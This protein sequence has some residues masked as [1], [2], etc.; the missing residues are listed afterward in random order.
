MRVLV[1]GA[2]G[3]IGGHVARHL[4]SIGHDVVGATRRPDTLS[5]FKVWHVDLADHH[6]VWPDEY[7]AV[8]HCAGTHPVSGASLA[9]TTHDNIVP[10]LRLVEMA[11]TWNVRL[12]VFMSTTSVY[13]SIVNGGVLDERSDRLNPSV[14]GETKHVCEQIL[15]EQPFPTISLRMPQ[16]VGLGAHERNWMPKV[17][18]DIVENRTVSAFN[19]DRD[20]NAA[21]HVGDVCDLVSK[22]LDKPP[23]GHDELVLGAGGATTVRDVITILGRRLGRSPQIFQVSDR[24]PSFVIRSDRAIEKY[25]YA[26]TEI[27]AMVEKYAVEFLLKD[28]ADRV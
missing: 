19:L 4:A 1:T 18:R 12:F 11:R 20:F 7:D 10:M 16:V 2:S 5:G 8:V 25:G 26:P 3:F 24:E 27:G 6:A 28:A 14:Y 15:R 22:L 9:K 13:G 23:A 17:A 21:V